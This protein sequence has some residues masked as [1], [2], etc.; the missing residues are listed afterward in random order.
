MT[1]QERTEEQLEEALDIIDDM[2]KEIGGLIITIAHSNDD[3]ICTECLR[4]AQTLFGLMKDY[5]S[6]EDVTDIRERW[7][8]ITGRDIDD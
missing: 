6:E 4:T 8:D 3:F 2:M 1:E 5:A 7:K